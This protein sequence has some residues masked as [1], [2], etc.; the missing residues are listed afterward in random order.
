MI[1]QH[2]EKLQ[3]LSGVG[4]IFFLPGSSFRGLSVTFQVSLA[5]RGSGHISCRMVSH[6]TS[7]FF[8]S[9]CTHLSLPVMALSATSTK[10]DWQMA[11]A[12]K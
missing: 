12:V 4:K 5:Q 2:S 6:S 9:L 1:L 7:T 3:R 8:H 11:V 10:Y